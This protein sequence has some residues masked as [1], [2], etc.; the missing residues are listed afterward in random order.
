MVEVRP[1][2]AM[3]IEWL[4]AIDHTRICTA[5][6]SSGNGAFLWRTHAPHEM[7]GTNREKGLRTH[8]SK[9]IYS[10]QGA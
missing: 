8:A 9:Q 10:I 4:E 6:L 2:G 3:F 5:T 7:N 1:F